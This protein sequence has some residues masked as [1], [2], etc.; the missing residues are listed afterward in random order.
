[1]LFLN[2][3]A[4]YIVGIANEV[5]V[6]FFIF[7]ILCCLIVTIKTKFIQ[8]RMFPKMFSIFYKSIFCKKKN[9][10]EGSIVPH[11]ALFTAMSTTIGISTIVG[12]SIAIRIGGPGALFGFLIACFL[13][14]AVNFTEIYY[15]FKYRRTMKCGTI[16]GGPMEYIEVVSGKY[17]SHIY[18]W[19][20]SILLAIWSGAQSNTLSD[21]VLYYN[22]PKLISGVIITSLVIFL[23]ISG[24]K[25]IGKFSAK[26]VPFMFVLYCIACFWILIVNANKIIP[27]LNLIVTSFFSLESFYGATAGYSFYSILRWG[28]AKGIHTSEVGIGTSTIPHA[29]SKAKNPFDQAVIGMFGCYSV[30]FLCLLSGLVII[31]TNTWNDTSIPLGIHI[32]RNAFASN[33]PYSS[34]I[35]ALCITL[36]GIGTILGNSYNG[37]QCYLYA[38]NNKKIFLYYLLVSAGI[39][40]GAISNNVKM[41]WGICDYFMIPVITINVFSIMLL[42]FKK[43]P[44]ENYK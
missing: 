11:H 14:V 13:G 33:I 8:I 20:L 39:F 25:T 19:I 30:L 43:P 37:A 7:L 38:T 24:I 10:Q 21:I 3:I 16:F 2:C 32:V 40:F 27:S 15:S 28:L 31:I 29:Q 1:M 17:L 22:I 5:L 18:A 36:F 6:V 34:L 9:K 12:P 44:K 4:N 23:L 26:I 41:L 35:L 42:L